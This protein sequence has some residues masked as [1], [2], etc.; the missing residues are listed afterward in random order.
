MSMFETNFR[1]RPSSMMPSVTFSVFIHMPLFGSACS[2]F[3]L[4]DRKTN[5]IAMV[6]PKTTMEKISRFEHNLV[7][8]S[9]ETLGETV[10]LFLTLKSLETVRLQMIENAAKAEATGSG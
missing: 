1:T 9:H 5:G 2:P 4:S 3:G 7:V 10:N 8:T 6:N